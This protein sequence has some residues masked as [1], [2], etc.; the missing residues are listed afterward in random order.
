MAIKIEK[1]SSA[2]DIRELP[3]HLKDQRTALLTP[4]QHAEVTAA[5]VGRP[6]SGKQVVSIRL[7]PEVITKFKATGPG[8]QSR[9]NAV[10]KSAKV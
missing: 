10:L 9:I 8:W 7:D 2:I 5:R 3:A 4:A 6:A 1:T